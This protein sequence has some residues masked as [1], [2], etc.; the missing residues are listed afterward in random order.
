MQKNEKIKEL[1]ED[2][3]FQNFE[4]LGEGT[5]GTV[6]K[7]FDKKVNRIVALKKI[8]LDDTENGFPSTTLREISILKEC[9]HNNVVR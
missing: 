9:S 1:F 8:K 5:Y 3:R 6:Y 4:K 2:E 7:A